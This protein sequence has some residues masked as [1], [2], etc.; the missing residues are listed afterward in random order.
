MYCRVPTP[1]GKQKL[2]KEIPCQGKHREI[3]NFAK[4]QGIWFARIVNYLILKDILIF[5]AKK[6]KILFEAGYV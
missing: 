4:T 6:S 2:V 5:A 3:G 1:E